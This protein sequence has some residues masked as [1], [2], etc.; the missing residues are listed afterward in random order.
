MRYRPFAGAVHVRGHAPLTCESSPTQVS[1]LG[2]DS[3]PSLPSRVTR[4]HCRAESSIPLALSVACAAGEVEAP[5]LALRLRAFGATLRG[6]GVGDSAQTLPTI[7][8]RLPS[9]YNTSRSSL[10]VTCHVPPSRDTRGAAGVA[11]AY[12][13]AFARN[14]NAGT[15]TAFSVTTVLLPLC[16]MLSATSRLPS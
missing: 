13:G 12:I 6:N 8:N 5:G 10:P 11:G 9:T 1:G 2:S 16:S 15:S 4:K 7:P 14:G 3:M